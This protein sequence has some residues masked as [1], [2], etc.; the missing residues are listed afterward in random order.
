ML[1]PTVQKD[2]NKQSVPADQATRA[3][4]H[5]KIGSFDFNLRE[6][7]GSLGDM[8]T[9]VPLAVGYIAVCGMEPAGILLMMGLA[10]I[11][12][13]LYYRLPIPIEPMKVIAAA[14]IAQQWPPS[15]ILASGFAMGIVWMLIAATGAASRLANLTPSAVV[16]GIQVALGILLAIEAG[17]LLSTSWLLGGLGL[18]IGIGFRKCRH[19]PAAVVLVLLGVAVMVI[20]GKFSQVIS[21]E[22]TL[23]H[24]ATFSFEE[25]WQSLVQA[26]FAQI[27]LT[28]TNATIATSC[29]ISSYWPDRQVSPQRLSVSQGAM[30]LIAPFFGGMPMCHGAGGLAGQYYFGARTGGTNIIEGIIEIVLGLFFAASVAGLF[31]SFPEAVTGTMLMLVGV[32]LVKFTRDV[33]GSRDTLAMA[34]TVA[35]SLASNMAFGFLA[36][37]LV[38]RMLP[39][40]NTGKKN[41]RKTGQSSQRSTEN[42][43]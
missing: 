20:N 10:N 8:G 22:V 39:Y 12:T 23:P 37:L 6:L 36:G 1:P 18:A 5:M 15:M 25:V 42:G 34:M 41:T 32:E 7:S 30:N 17:K 19:A 27:P 35:V 21:P 40:M 4:K 43:D 9:F 26:G 28:V 16:R 2:P 3:L 11:A 14:A 33:R 31:A 24:L 38:N 13:G 29:L